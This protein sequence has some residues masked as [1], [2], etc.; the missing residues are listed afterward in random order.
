MG[1]LRRNRVRIAGAWV[2]LLA[3]LAIY[4]PL[5]AAA[6]LAHGMACCTGDH[7]PIKQHHHQKKQAAH[8]SDMDCGHDMGEM[9]NCSMA[10]CDDSEKPVTAAVAFVLPE[11]QDV[12]SSEAI[13]GAIE[14]DQEMAIFRT[15]VPLSPPPQVAAL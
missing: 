5:G 2:C 9:I 6:W 10:C 1:V 12:N 14:A 15:V 7:C 3:A 11:L 4:A 13:V 8:H